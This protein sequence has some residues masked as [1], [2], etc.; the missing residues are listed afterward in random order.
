MS[1]D[2]QLARS[3][4]DTFRQVVTD[5]LNSEQRLGFERMIQ[6]MFAVPNLRNV[7]LWTRFGTQQRNFI[8]RGLGE[9]ELDLR[10]FL[11]DRFIQNAVPN[12]PTKS[13]GF[14]LSNDPQV[15]KD[16][17]KWLNDPWIRAYCTRVFI[18]GNRIFVEYAADSDNPSFIPDLD[19]DE[20]EDL[21]A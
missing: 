6:V 3:V 8:R 18:L 5:R 13:H 2:D 1:F 21:V 4:S 11:A 7:Q 9:Q 12:F 15:V 14:P 20:F 19:S 17:F 10:L 16:F